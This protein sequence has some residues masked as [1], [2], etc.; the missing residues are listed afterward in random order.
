MVLLI[1]RTRHGDVTLP[2]GKVDPGETL[3]QTAVRE[4]AEETGLAVALGVPLGVSSYPLPERPRQD[5]ALLGGRGDEARHRA[6]RP[7]CRTA[8]SPRSSGC[9][10]KKARRRPQLRARRR[11]PRAFAELAA[12]GV[13]DTFA[14]IVAAPRQGGLRAAPGRTRHRPPA[15]RSAACE[16]ASAIVPALAAWGPHAHRDAARPRAAWPP[17]RRS[18]QAPASGAKRRTRSARTPGRLR[19]RR[20]SAVR[21]VVAS[22]IAKGRT[23]C[24]AATAPV[25]PE[26][27]RADR[28]GDGQR[29]TAAA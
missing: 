19:R 16:Q 10:S 13:L 28:P 14:L 2:K 9:R 12:D 7:S 27:L 4:I 6:A 22:A 15:H 8:R 5:R 25:L 20:P 17:S 3:P 23:R 21:E 11:D 1:H 29:R 18:P 26:I 24:S